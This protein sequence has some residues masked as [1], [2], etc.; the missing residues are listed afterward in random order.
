MLDE[1]VDMVVCPQFLFQHCDPN[2]KSC[3]R[4]AIDYSASSRML[5]HTLS[6]SN[7]QLHRE[8]V[9]KAWI[10]RGNAILFMKTTRSTALSW[11]AGGSDL[12]PNNWTRTCQPI[13]GVSSS[14]SLEYGSAVARCSVGQPPIAMHDVSDQSVD[15]ATVGPPY[16]Q[17]YITNC[18]IVQRW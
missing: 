5:I 1:F 16:L 15:R 12:K 4:D 8:N 6:N 13:Q 11:T 9:M 17:K 2:F 10:D 18:S 3:N 7:A 14:S